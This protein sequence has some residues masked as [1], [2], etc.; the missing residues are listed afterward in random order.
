MTYL[1]FGHPANR[2]I[3]KFLDSFINEL[4][5]EKNFFPAVNIDESNDSYYLSFMAPGRKKEDFKI[6]V[7]KNILTVSY[8]SPADEQDENKQDENKKEIRRE[9]SLQPFKRTFTLDEKV[10]ADTIKASYENGILLVNL[11]KKEEVKIKP[12]EITIQ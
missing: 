5:T 1:K 3:N 9:F 12:K 6:T 11:P 4:P 7:D 8:D 2:N 10:A